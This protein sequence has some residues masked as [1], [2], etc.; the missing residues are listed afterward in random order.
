MPGSHG[1]VRDEDIVAM[2]QER[3]FDAVLFTHYHGDHTGLMDRIPSDVPLY[4][5]EAM[6]KILTTLHKYTRNEAMN[7]LL[8]DTDGRIHVFVPP[9]PFFVGD[10]K[11][12]PFFVD[13]KCGLY[14]LYG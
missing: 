12:T 14:L 2:L 5:D 4:M 8:A 11:I 6:K 10:M 3:H 1:T 9:T 7:A 13:Q